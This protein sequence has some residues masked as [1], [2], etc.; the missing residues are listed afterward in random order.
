MKYI[1]SQETSNREVEL[2][3]SS[4]CNMVSKNKYKNY[5]HMR[6]AV[7]E[8]TVGL[9]VDIKDLKNSLINHKGKVKVPEVRQSVLLD[10]R[11][12]NKSILAHELK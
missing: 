12:K 4:A 5:D 9:Y 11:N 3:F 10:I 7:C 6:R 1:E 2:C 8:L